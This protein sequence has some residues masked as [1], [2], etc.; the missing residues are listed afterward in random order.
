[1]YEPYL[2]REKQYLKMNAELD[3]RFK[4]IDPM[5]G[6]ALELTKP[7]LNVPKVCNQT[8]KSTVVAKPKRS[9]VKIGAGTKTTVVA[10]SESRDSSERHEN[11]IEI[12]KVDDR[13]IES[14]RKL[15]PQSIETKNP[16]SITNNLTASNHDTIVAKKNISS[17]GLIKY[18][19][20]F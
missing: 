14:K 9:D 2:N 5:K 10:L 19:T 4:E 16:T 8:T 7:R 6:D 12:Q 18:K 11:G 15:E 20:E 1:M 13:E 3:S 17:D